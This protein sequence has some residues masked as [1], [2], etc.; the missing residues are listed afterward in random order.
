MDQRLK[1]VTGVLAITQILSWGSTFYLPG[2]VGRDIARDL[3]I[4]T[5]LVYGGVTMMVVTSAFLSP[6]VG[7]VFDRHGTRWFMAGGSVMLSA[8]LGL[9][10][11][12]QSPAIYLAAWGIIGVAS[13]FAMS[14]PATTTLAQVA[15]GAARRAMIVLMLF[16]GLSSTILWPVTA[17]ME[18]QIGWRGACLVYALVHLFVC[19]PLHL[20]G[21]P[22]G[23]HAS[24]PNGA[25][26]IVTAGVASPD[27][28]RSIFAALAVA[29]SLSGFV[30]WGLSL[31]M[32][33]LL[34]AGGLSASAAITLASAIGAMQVA[35]RLL[36]F[37]LGNRVSPVVPGLLATALLP[38]SFALF[39][40]A[41]GSAALTVTFLVAY[42]IA[43]GLIAVA[44]ATL[45]LW[46]FG[47]AVYGAASGRLM[48]A[49]NIAFGI[50]PV[51]FAAAM[52]EGLPV[53]ILLALASAGVAC[54]AMFAVARMVGTGWR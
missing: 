5:G 50:A 31:H 25:P 27:R 15:G 18:P 4:S 13:V 9:M 36:E 14:L 24:G 33:A 35:A 11:V 19:V 41:D 48:L 45:P 29:F 46:L 47:S 10:A 53:A 39:Y 6:L 42:A 49:Q 44:R 23:V 12:A 34:E 51:V 38:L 30:S 28:S 54:A 1:R 16:T 3:G 17:M 32:I 43:T 20:F 2:I 26:K 8:G 7:P 21:L 40:F 52:D 37:L 22:R